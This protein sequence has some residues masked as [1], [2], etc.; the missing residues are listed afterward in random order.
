M[1]RKLSG[2]ISS[3]LSLWH[4]SAGE[5]EERRRQG[6]GKME[7]TGQPYLVALVLY[8]QQLPSQPLQNEVTLFAL[9]SKVLYTVNQNC[10]SFS[11]QYSAAQSIH[12][13]SLCVVT[14]Y[15]SQSVAAWEYIGTV[16][17]D[18]EERGD[19]GLQLEEDAFRL[20]FAAV[21]LE[22]LNDPHS[23]TTTVE[24]CVDVCFYTRTHF[25]EKNFS[26]DKILFFQ[27]LESKKRFLHQ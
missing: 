10:L 13:C 6:P 16:L 23:L 20:L 5:R 8:A 27:S 15:L 3:S 24:V 25:T 14:L 1:E 19:G 11:R 12:N 17:S 4:G 26:C 21:G 22:L 9:L 2:M 7:E 18:M